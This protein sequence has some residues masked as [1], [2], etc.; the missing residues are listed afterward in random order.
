MREILTTHTRRE[1]RLRRNQFSLIP[2]H[3]GPVHTGT[4]RRKKRRRVLGGARCSEDVAS[5]GASAPLDVARCCKVLP[6]SSTAQGQLRLACQEP[7]VILLGAAA[8]W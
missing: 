5:S 4:V 3:T 7:A 8:L 6:S 2:V 1:D